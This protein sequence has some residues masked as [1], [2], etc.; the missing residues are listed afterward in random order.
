MDLIAQAQQALHNAVAQVHDREQHVG[1]FVEQLEQKIT[2]M[3]ERLN[4][5]TASNDSTV[6]SQA[7]IVQMNERIEVVHANMHA[8]QETLGMLNIAIAAE[9]ASQANTSQHMTVANTAR[10][11]ATASLLEANTARDAA[12]ASLRSHRCSRRSHRCSRRSHCFSS[13]SKRCSRHS[14]R[15]S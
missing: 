13:R 14:H 7:A 3:Q 5:A 12:T 1:S 8:L 15:C 6:E 2:D 4:S 11:A 9:Q 10:D